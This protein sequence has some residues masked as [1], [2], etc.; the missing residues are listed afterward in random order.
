MRMNETWQRC[1]EFH[2]HSCPGLAT[3]C[4]AAEAACDHL[5]IEMEKS[6]D[7]ELVC[8]AETDACGVD[9]IQCLLSCT[10]GKGNMILRLTGNHAFS[11]H[12]RRTGKSV[13]IVSKHHDGSL[14]REELTDFILNGPVNEVFEFK[15]ATV[16]IP[17]K[18]RIFRSGICAC[19][20]ESVREDLL[21]IQDGN[22]VCLDCFKPYPGRWNRKAD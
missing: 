6:K 5:G 4:R 12:D 9:A 14:S 10:L 13:R 18:A 16:G 19:C 21:R 7:E 3:G 15:E 2:G 17:E 11:F 8:I 20:H 22:T 1:Q